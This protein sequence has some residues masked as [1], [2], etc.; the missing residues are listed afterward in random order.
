VAIGLATP[1]ASLAAANGTVVSARAH[2]ASQQDGRTKASARGLK[3]DH[4]YHLTLTA[5]RAPLWLYVD[6]P[7]SFQPYVFDATGPASPHKEIG[8]AFV[9]A[10]VN[11]SA[12]CAVTATLG[13][14]AT[15]QQLIAYPDL[16][17]T[18]PGIAKRQGRYYLSLSGAGAE[19]A[20]APVTVTV[21]VS[22]AGGHA[23]SLGVTWVRGQRSPYSGPIVSSSALSGKN[24][25]CYALGIAES[26]A[27]HEFKSDFKR[28][29]QR[30]NFI[31]RQRR[32]IR[33][34]DG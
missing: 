34:A 13:S 33:C 8:V 2:D 12:S 22:R 32:R 27:E 5:P 14:G 10:S 11:S 30:V 17:V 6:I 25:D 15:A 3:A 28:L 1:G 9:Q 16:L 31:E 20:G 18:V 19:C 29:K 26:Y 23:A 4:S 21:T 7:R 24:A